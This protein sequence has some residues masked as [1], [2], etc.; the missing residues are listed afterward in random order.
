MAESGISNAAL[1]AINSANPTKLSD[2]FKGFTEDAALE[3]AAKVLLKKND[4]V[5][6]ELPS[7]SQAIQEQFETEKRIREELAKIQSNKKGG[8]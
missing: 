1:K 4:K 7:K 8:Q 3:N 6:K 2:F 5:K